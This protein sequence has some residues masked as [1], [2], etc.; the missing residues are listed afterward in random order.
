MT[1][2]F[3][4]AEPPAG[5]TR[6]RSLMIALLLAFALVVGLGLSGGGQD[7]S[8]GAVVM[9]KPSVTLVPARS[10]RGGPSSAR[11]AIPGGARHGSS[12]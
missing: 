2:A 9:P 3:L 11:R 6:L 10:V 1:P 8:P 7:P 12:R 5:L 4:P